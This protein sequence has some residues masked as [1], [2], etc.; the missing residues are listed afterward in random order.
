[1][2]IKIINPN[3]YIDMTRS[4]DTI[5]KRCARPDT[6]IVT[7]SPEHGPFTIE[8][9]FDKAIATVG[10]IEEIKKGVL[11]HFDGYVIAC[12]G[13][14]GLYAGR[15]IAEAPVIGAAE[16]SFYMA[17][18]LGHRFSIISILDRF[19][20]TMEELVSKYGLDNRCASIRCTNVPVADFERDRQKGEA[21]LIQTARCAVEEDGAEVICLGCAGMVAFD[22]VMERTLHV[23]VID[24]VVAAVKTAESVIDTGKRTSKIKTFRP[25]EKK[26]IKGYSEIMQP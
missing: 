4:I 16:A 3:T 18:M 11:E 13:D 19:K 26:V 25:P 9:N 24:P 1:M 21:A 5:A 8:D 14:P 10:T 17:C 23:P 6:E 12:F 22:E 15:E 7:V 20:S 2:R